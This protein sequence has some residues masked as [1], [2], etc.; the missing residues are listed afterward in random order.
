[1]FVLTRARLAR[2]SL[3]V[4]AAA[5]LGGCI[6][7]PLGQTGGVLPANDIGPPPSMR[8]ELRAAARSAAPADA[9]PDQVV[10]TAPTRRL[11]VPTTTRAGRG[12]GGDVQPRRIRREDLEDYSP[13][14][15]GSGGLTPAIGSG[16][17]VGVGGRF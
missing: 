11:D 2:A 9:D 16:G 17:S 3:A 10:A 5:L 6:N 14:S 13:S 4:A 15:G 12:A 8:G 7:N 1:M